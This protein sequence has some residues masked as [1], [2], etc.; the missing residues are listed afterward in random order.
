MDGG[1]QAQDSRRGGKQHVE[2]NCDELED[3]GEAEVEVNEDRRETNLVSR[4]LPVFFF[5]H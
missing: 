2:E 1:K 4:V 3:V 5:H